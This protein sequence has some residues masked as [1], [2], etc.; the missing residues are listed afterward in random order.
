MKNMASYEFLIICFSFCRKKIAEIHKIYVNQKKN[1][2]FT[3]NFQ[4][5]PKFLG[6]TEDLPRFFP[7][8]P[9]FSIYRDFFQKKTEISVIYRVY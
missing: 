8:K 1:R 7:K 4:T 5:K 2:N 6:F 3:Q 9:R